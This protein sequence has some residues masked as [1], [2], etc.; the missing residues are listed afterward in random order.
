MFVNIMVGFAKP[1]PTLYAATRCAGARKM[2]KPQLPA[3]AEKI[4]LSWS[5]CAVANR[6]GAASQI[7]SVP[8][9]VASGSGAASR[10][11]S[12]PLA[13]ASGSG[14]ASRVMS[15]PLAVAS[16]SGTA[17]APICELRSRALD[18]QG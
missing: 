16:G 2:S 5:I 1:H 4:S 9:A 14:A 8:L 18:S 17:F 11:M 7:M 10:V 15:V 13:V 3:S 12:V 6:S